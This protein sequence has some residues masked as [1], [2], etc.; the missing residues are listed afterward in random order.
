M[1]FIL[2]LKS[3]QLIIILKRENLKKDNYCKTEEV[4]IFS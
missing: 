4:I 1:T 3:T 2:S